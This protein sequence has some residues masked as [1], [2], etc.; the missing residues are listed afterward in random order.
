MLLRKVP[1]IIDKIY[2]D[3]IWRIKKPN[4]VFLT[5]DDGPHPVLTPWLLDF[6][7]NENIP[8]NFFWLGENIERY[9]KLLDE[10]RSKGHFIGNHGYSHLNSSKVSSASYIANF[11]KSKNLV[12]KLYFRPPYGVLSRKN[13]QIIK[14]SSKIVMWTWISCDWEEKESVEAII[15]NLDK[16]ISQHQL[17]V[18]HENE[19]SKD[20]IPKLMPRVVEIMRK[21]NLT[22]ELLA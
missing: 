3:R 7:K 6:A 19:K 18:F 8:L 14:G 20:K 13:E 2:P 5:F 21:H 10:A 4:A 16:N 22:P 17:L 15:R 1:K 12:P 11:E 9:P